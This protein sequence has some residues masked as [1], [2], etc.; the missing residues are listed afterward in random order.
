MAGLAVGYWKDQEEIKENW[1]L[2]RIFEPD[3][4]EELR[5]KKV[6]GWKKAVKRSLLWDKE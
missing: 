4:E 1:K 3:M 5:Q 6:S 2:D